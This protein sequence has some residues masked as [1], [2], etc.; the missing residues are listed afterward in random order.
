MNTKGKNEQTK[1]SNNPLLLLVIGIYLTVLLFV[2][3]IA[4]LFSY[5]QRKEEV[6]SNMEYTFIQLE[7][8]YTKTVENFWQIYMP[9]FENRTEIHTAI[10]NYF[11]PNT[12][13]DLTPLERNELARALN[14]MMIRD[15]Q[16]QWIALF[17]DQRETNYLL[18]RTG[19][20][21]KVI[22]DSFPYLENLAKKQNQMEIYGAAPI[23]NNGNTLNTYA[24]CG[25][26]P[27]NMGSGKIIAGYSLSSLE[28]ICQSSEQSLDSLNY[29]LN[30]NGQVLFRSSHDSSEKVSYLPDSSFH[31]IRKESSGQKTFVHANTCGLGSVLSFQFSPQEFFLYSHRNTPRILLIV[32]AFGL[33]SIFVYT[34]MLKHITKEV[35]IIKAGLE[36]LSKNQLTYH[37]PTNFKQSGLHEIA[38]SINLMAE[39]LNENIHR[40]YCYE[41]KQ[42]EAELSEL[43]AKFNP[44]FLY[45]SLEMIRSRCYQNE[46]EKTAELVTQLAAIF[47]GFIGS[48]TFIPLPEE[49]AFSKRYLSLFGAR[50]KDQVQIHYD[51]NTELLRYGII[52]NVLQPLIENYFIHG[53]ETSAGE[54]N[55]I[56]FHGKSLDDH[57]M[58]LTVE[59]NGAGMTDTEL[60]QLNATLHEPVKIDMESYGLKN[61]HQRLQLFYGNDCGLSIERNKDKG[62]S[63][64]MKL[65]KITC[66][67]Y[68]AQRCSET[69]P[70]T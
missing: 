68:D 44:H 69:I 27:F 22:P 25:G 10:F 31:G 53:F 42:K 18:F 7:Q 28:Q 52:R 9:I 6:L 45:N 48:K 37:I 38:E 55:Y 47:R 32:I 14:Q 24:I 46:D 54:N 59:D 19:N 64:H 60:Q 66:E 43:Q 26:V 20:S 41:L 36:V 13:E 1:V 33:F 34:L 3:C 62:I 61:L 63:I 35:G 8:D 2:S 17:S 51:I 70:L 29:L 4:C 49:L 65:L 23:Q 56:C 30:V 58:L 5:Y 57:S 11:A 15:S 67:E 21:L 39:R 12:T 40:A 50:Y 16:I